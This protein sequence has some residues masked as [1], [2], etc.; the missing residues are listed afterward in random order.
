MLLLSDIHKGTP[1][2]R[3]SPRKPPDLLQH[4]GANPG[5]EAL[6]HPYQGLP[7]SSK[8]RTAAA[9]AGPAKRG[10]GAGFFA[11]LPGVRGQN[12]GL[13]R[14]FG[15][16][17]DR[18]A[19]TVPLAGAAPR[20]PVLIGQTIQQLLAPGHSR[21]PIRARSY[22]LVG[23]AEQFGRFPQG[24]PSLR[25]AM[26]SVGGARPGSPSV[27]LIARHGGSWMDGD[28]LVCHDLPCQALRA[29]LTMIDRA[30]WS[31]GI[32]RPSGPGVRRRRS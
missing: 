23:D 17:T 28:G 19:F 29:V 16:C 13:T 32:G 18:G 14:R 1:V 7:P 15:G 12:R 4:A 30:A 20:R 9:G 8:T 31:A 22:P 6:S 2:G 27:M 3:Q 5:Q 10:E 24:K 26:A 21:L 25:A 11:F